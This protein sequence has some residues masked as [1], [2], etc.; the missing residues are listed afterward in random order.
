[1]ADGRIKTEFAGLLRPGLWPMELERLSELCVL[2]DRFKLSATRKR[3]L[4]SWREIGTVLSAG[5]I[6]GDI[7]ID[8]SY[9]TEK[10]DPEDIDML[11]RVP[12]SLYDSDPIKRGIIDWATS[13]DR[14]DSHSC[15]SYLWVE[16]T[17]GH[18]LHAESDSFLK[19]WERWFG[20][21]RLG[22]PKG[23]AVLSVPLVE[24][25]LGLS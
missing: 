6:T 11:L 14:W 15:D 9:L 19:Y 25:I 4:K 2:D 7:W 17:E 13:P 3:I 8:G 5:G 24:P 23:I 1:M 22:E 16:Y 21:S 10:I 18:P 20:H 12:S